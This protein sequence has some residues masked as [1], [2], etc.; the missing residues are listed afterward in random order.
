MRTYLTF[1]ILAASLTAS[2][3]HA[4]EWPMWGGRPDRNMRAEAKGIPD[5]IVSGKFLPKNETI[6]AKTTK[7]IR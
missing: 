2:T 4:G 5:D 3:L 1:S 6:N 7:N